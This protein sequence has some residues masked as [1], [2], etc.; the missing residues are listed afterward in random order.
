MPIGGEGGDGVMF[1]IHV[2]GALGFLEGYGTGDNSLM[3]KWFLQQKR[4]IRIA[5]IFANHP[6]WDLS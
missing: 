6:G 3:G 5:I 2:C 1:H 4:Y